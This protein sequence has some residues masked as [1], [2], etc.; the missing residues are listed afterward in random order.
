MQMAPW[1]KVF[2]YIRT[3]WCEWKHWLLFHHIQ[4]YAGHPAWHTSM[5]KNS[6]APLLFFFYINALSQPLAISGIM[7][8]S[9][10]PSHPLS[11]IV[12]CLMCGCVLLVSV[13]SLQ[14]EVALALGPVPQLLLEKKSLT[15]E[16]VALACT[17]LGKTLTSE[18][19]A[20][21]IVLHETGHQMKEIVEQV[22]VCEHY[23]W[24]WVRHFKDDIGIM[25]IVKP[26]FG[27]SKKTSPKIMTVIKKELTIGP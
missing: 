4:L 17:R 27:E 18:I 25:P 7:P 14:S 15:T 9:S 12:A 21:N 24:K 22:G 1:E 5:T 13:I 20:W 6:S 11:A 3:Q 26:C 19:I 16:T 10:H 2:L 23:V 8:S